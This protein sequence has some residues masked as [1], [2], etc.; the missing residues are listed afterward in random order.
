MLAINAKRGVESTVERVFNSTG[1]AFS[2][3]QVLWTGKTAGI[4]FKRSSIG[5]DAKIVFPAID[6]GAE[7]KRSTFN[8]LIGY[9]I[10]E[11]GHAWF[12]TNEPWDKARN[13]YGQFV[14]NLI[15]GLEDP[16]IERKVI[17]S[18]YAPNA[19]ALFEELLNSILK[20]N[21]Y[22]E[23]DDLKNVPFLLAVEGRRLNGYHVDA[24]SVT[25]L[26]PWSA[27]LH[28]A[29]AEAQLAKDTK[30]IAEIAIELFK[31]LKDFEPEPTDGEEEGDEEGEEGQEG[32]EE[33]E[34]GGGFPIKGDKPTDQPSD[35]PTEDG[36][37]GKGNEP[38]DKPTDGD[39]EGDDQGGDKGG[40]EGE[41][42]SE[43]GDQPSD[44]GEPTDENKSSEE[45]K[46]NGGGKDFD[47]GRNV[48][49]N[50]FIEGELNDQKTN[51]TK[52]LDNRP[53]SAKPTLAT[54]EWL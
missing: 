28:W 46:K 29:L 12:T 2:K 1:N 51:L 18:G 50:E 48:E 11:L 16:R 30:R 21:G 33:G 9:A 43:G 4:L 38:T 10:H 54:F 26:A 23:A 32:E 8:N 15:N 47:G 44:K 36:E 40:Q 35:K 45:G 31:R 6:E 52:R 20:K 3:L 39:Q 19:K 53:S 5:V 17:E 24:P 34:E 42:G 14:G 49:P 37:D 13:D 7:M 27:D 22:V 25:D 41:K